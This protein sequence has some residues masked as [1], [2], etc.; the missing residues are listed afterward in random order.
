M[1]VAN[2][3]DYYEVLGVVRE[4]DEVSLKTAYRKLALKYHPDRNPENQEAE[5]LFKEAAEAYGVLSDP[6]KRAAYDRFGH[7][8]VQGAGAS[9]FD[10]SAFGDFSDVLGDLFGFGDLFGTG[11]KRSRVQRGE[12]LRFDLEIKLEDAIRGMTADIQVPRMDACGRCKGTGAE[13]EDGIVTCSVCRG[14]GEV[15][16]QQGFLTVRRTCGQCNGRGQLIRR[17][18]TQC[19]GEGRVRSDRK[20]KVTIPAG[21]DSNTR[22]RLQSE[23]QPGPNG[24]PAGDLYVVVSIQE[25]PVF[26]RHESD[27]HCV[28]PINVAQAALGTE[29]TLDTF[30]G[31]QTV[32]V[33]EG[34]SPGQRIRLRGLGVPHLQSHGRGDIYVHIEVKVP[35]RLSK[36]QR[37][38]FEQLQ[39]TLP[40]DNEPK[41][42]SILDKVKDYF[43]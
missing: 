14:R 12:D 8:G 16:Y 23:G 10:P 5:E 21:V 34:A 25:H 6:Q 43:M 38:L 7:Q 41:T 39:A 18:C 42:K 31:Q 40:A 30:D 17:P 13:R 19:R 4:V 32:K 36:E 33:P 28:I 24:G 27:L 20:L 22:L 26:E 37:K 15:L 35:S 1:S 9:G 29:L 3:R 11:R 2:K